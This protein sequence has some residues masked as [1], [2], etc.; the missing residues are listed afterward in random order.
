MIGQSFGPTFSSVFGSQKFLQ[1]PLIFWQLFG[2]G[3]D[4]GFLVGV[5]VMVG[6]AKVGAG[7]PPF[8]LEQQ[9]I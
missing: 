7:V 3:V 1:E 4:V 9:T 6:P 5:G 2:T 8:L